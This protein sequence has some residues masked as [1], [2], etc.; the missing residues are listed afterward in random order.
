MGIKK[1][2]EGHQE[3]G[4]RSGGMTWRRLG[5][6]CRPVGVFLGIEPPLVQGPFQVFGG[7]QKRARGAL[8]CMIDG[9][10]GEQKRQIFQLFLAASCNFHQSVC[11]WRLGHALGVH[12]LGKGW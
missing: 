9:Q 6:F 8:Q 11:W 10:G 12:M 3:Q 5:P 2:Q 1:G 7:N 4:R